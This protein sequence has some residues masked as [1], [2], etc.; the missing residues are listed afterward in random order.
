MA[1]G[2]ATFKSNILVREEK[3]F[4]GIPFKR[5]LLAFMAG[6]VIYMVSNFFLG[7]I[8]LG[9]G[10]VSAV[11]TI[12][13]TQPRGG[14]PLWQRLLYRVRGRLI[15]AQVDASDSIAASLG[16]FLELHSDILVLTGDDLFHAPEDEEAE[17]VDWSEWMTYTDPAQVQ[18]G[19]ALQI[20]EGPQ[21][22]ARPAAALAAPK[23]GV[24]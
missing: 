5:M 8:S 23:G 19:E 17:A 6:S 9:L 1:S 20:V 2:E 22:L 18:S 3:G 16:K 13:L 24:A 10:V 7:S 11:L 14:I 15:M 21:A 4:F 12:I